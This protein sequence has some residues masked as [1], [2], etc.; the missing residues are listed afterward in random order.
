[1]SAI[2][3]R[4][5]W[6]VQATLGEGVFWHAAN[7]RVYFVDIKGRRIYRCA[8][9]GSERRSWEAP[10][11]ITFVLP[12]EGGGLVAAMEDGLYRFDEYS[13]ALTL[14]RHVEREQPGNRSNDGYVD[15]CGR[16][17]FGTMDDAQQAPTGAL[18]RYDGSGEPQRLDE[19]YIITNGPAVSPDGRTLYHTDTLARRTY[20]FD[21]APDG[22]I[23]GKR[24][25]AAFDDAP[26]HPDGMAVDADG[27]VWIA[28]FR[29]WRIDRFAP[30]GKKIGSVRFPCSNITK[31]AFAGDDLRTVYVTTARKGLSTEELAAQPLAGALFTFRADAPGLAQ[32]ALRLE[33]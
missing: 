25:F 22:S 33:E 21:L 15:A 28:V 1:M 17:W 7:D 12:V 4:C 30:D 16:L 20:A 23:E 5:I 24:V 19:G 26:G 9:D 29:G 18:Y 8:P 31:L 13:G 3:P 10:Q 11:Q 6:E 27:C 32:H 14:M 2:E